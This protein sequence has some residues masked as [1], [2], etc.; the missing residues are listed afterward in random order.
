MF[1]S[2]SH[3]VPT[4]HNR[5]PLLSSLW[6][7]VGCGS[8]SQIHFPGWLWGINEEPTLSLFSKIII[9]SDLLAYTTRLGLWP[10]RNYNQ[11][12]PYL[13]DAPWSHVSWLTIKIF[14]A[15]DK[16][17]YLSEQTES[18]ARFPDRY[19]AIITSTLVN[20][21]LIILFPTWPSIGLDPDSSWFHFM[22]ALASNQH[23]CLLQTASLDC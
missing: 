15:K 21:I 14:H 11:L 20:S 2:G 7:Y 6:L 1:A 12:F 5:F 3:R 4:G 19:L 22:V 17:T 10:T 13:M 18:N 9:L 16:Q 8:W 23:F